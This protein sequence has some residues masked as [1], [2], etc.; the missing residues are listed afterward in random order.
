MKEREELMVVLCVDEK[1]NKAYIKEMT[2]MGKKPQEE[3]GN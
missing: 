2:A 1:M 3:H